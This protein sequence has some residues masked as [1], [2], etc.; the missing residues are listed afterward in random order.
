MPI[1][2]KH[3]TVIAV[4]AGHPEDPNWDRVHEEVA[5]RLETA[6]HTFTLTKEQKTH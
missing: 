3:G 6:C 1:T 4:L 2:D 5:D